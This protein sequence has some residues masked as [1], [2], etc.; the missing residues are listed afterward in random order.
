MTHWQSLHIKEEERVNSVHRHGQAAVGRQTMPAGS[1]EGDLQSTY[2][3]SGA[4]LCHRASPNMPWG[5]LRPAGSQAGMGVLSFVLLERKGKQR[6]SEA[7]TS[8]LQDVPEN[9][10]NDAGSRLG[11][12]WR[13]LIIMR[14]LHRTS[15]HLGQWATS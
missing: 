9:L 10:V 12:D 4:P 11:K 5:E 13:K 1:C 7:H 2:P 15:L 6:R 14:W 8:T 3:D